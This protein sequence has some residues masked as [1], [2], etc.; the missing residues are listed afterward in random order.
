M[1]HHVVQPF[2]VK[3]SQGERELLPG[4]LINLPTD[5]ALKLVNEGKITPAERVAYHVYSEILQTYLW[6]VDTDADR[7]TIR[8]KGIAEAIYSRQEIKKIMKLHGDDLRDIHKV[9]EVF[10]DSAVEQVKPKKEHQE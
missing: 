1:R 5:K 9:K 2:K 4:Q 6:V 7:H 8:A 10:Q 3:T